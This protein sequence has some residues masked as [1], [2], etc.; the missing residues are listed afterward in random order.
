MSN[1]VT[2]STWSERKQAG[3]AHEDRIRAELG[4]RGWTVDLLGQGAMSEAVTAVLGR[5][6]STLRYLPEFI[7]ARHGDLCLID[8]KGRISPHTGRHSI[9]RAAVQA[10]VAMRSFFD[11]PIYYVFET[12]GVMTPFDVQR[13]ADTRVGARGS[14]YLVP[15]AEARP[16]DVFF[17]DQQFLFTAPDAA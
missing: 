9:S 10:H 3:D 1:V 13:F 11:L 6:R 16:F 14:Y 8:C 7:A 12:M 15:S 17:G 5:T 4:V 2:L